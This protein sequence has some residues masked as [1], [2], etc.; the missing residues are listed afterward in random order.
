MVDNGLIA[1][2]KKFGL[3]ENEAKA[4]T[5][6]VFLGDAGVRDLH[7][8]TKIPRAKLYEVLESLVNKRYAEVLHGSPIHYRA[9][10]PDDLIQMLREDYEKTASEI[11]QAFEEMDYH[12]LTDN[13][14]EMALIQYLRSEWTVRRKMNELFDRTRKNI[15]LFSRSPA[16]LKDIESDLVSIQDR[17]NILILVDNIED[18]GKFSLPLMVYPPN[19]RPILKGLEVSHLTNQSC[20]IISDAGV[21]LAIRKENSRIEAHYISQPMVDFLYKTIYYFIQHADTIELPEELKIEYNAESK[22]EFKKE[23]ESTSSESDNSPKGC[24]RGRIKTKIKEA[25]ENLKHGKT[26]K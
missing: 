15:I 5:G 6:L 9:T 17:I 10:D 23:S 22:T 11:S 19:V 24:G 18:Y 8:F 12:L 1:N 26:R 14:D 25:T 21:S 20:S 4:Y 2:L 7:E 13:G 3:S 16:I